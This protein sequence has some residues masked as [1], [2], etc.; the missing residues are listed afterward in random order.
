MG[1]LES[2]VSELT[3]SRAQLLSELEKCQSEMKVS[4]ESHSNQLQALE[5]ENDMLR[6]QLKKYVVMVQA[7]RR[8]TSA[9]TTESVAQM[10]TNSSGTSTKN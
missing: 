1:E 8:E 10:V 3:S 9:K 4:Q 7:Q 2:Q 5:R 6:E